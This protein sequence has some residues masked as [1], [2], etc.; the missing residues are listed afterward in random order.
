VRTNLSSSRQESIIQGAIALIHAQG[1]PAFSYGDLAKQLSISKGVLT[2]HYAHKLL[3]TD[4]VVEYIIADYSRHILFAL[5]GQQDPVAIMHGYI[6]AVL[7]YTF[8]H[9]VY[10]SVLMEVGSTARNADGS[11]RYGSHFRQQALDGISELLQQ[12]QAADVFGQCDIPM[13]AVLIKGTLDEY[14]RCRFDASDIMLHGERH[15]EQDIDAIIGIIDDLILKNK[16]GIV[17]R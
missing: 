3:L 13:T 9:P 6:R 12:G 2:Y 10:I 11:L 5:D 7:T 17:S 15:I 8:Q 16:E 14:V 1:F 4:A